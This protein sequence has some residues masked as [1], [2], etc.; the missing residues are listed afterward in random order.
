M[1]KRDFFDARI[2]VVDD[3]PSNTRLV[4]EL[5]RLDGYKHIESQN[6]SAQ[7]A[8]DFQRF[9]PDLVILD[10][11]MKP[12]DGF[13]VLAQLDPL[14]PPSAFLPILMLTGNIDQ[15]AKAHALAAGAIDF[16]TKPFNRTELLL[17]VKN[18]LHTRLL[19]LE[20][21]EERDGLER[22]I[23]ERTEEV[24]E[25]RNEALERLALAAEY[26]DDET[27]EHTRRVAEMV[28]SIAR[29]LGISDSEADT[30]GKAALLHD[31]GKVGIRDSVLLKPGRYTDEERVA[32]REHSKIGGDI[33]SGSKSKL[34]QIA[35]EIARYHHERWDGTGHVGLKGFEIPIHARITAVADVYDALVNERPYK[36]AW[37]PRLAIAE[38]ERSAGSHFD[39]DV[40]KAFLQVVPTLNLKVA[41]QQLRLAA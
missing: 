2:L 36:K 40:V 28:A 10:L 14:V 32:M 11:H 19:Y 6:D 27:G 12:Y 38:I 21:Q 4:T 5:L 41:E 26:R 17:R 16:L 39:P 18:L 3:E 30:M 35:E 22:R 24:V 31:L 7:V 20:I 25:A 15:E 13:D 9:Q 1:H 34:L 37:E 33:L 29:H 23:L 8:L